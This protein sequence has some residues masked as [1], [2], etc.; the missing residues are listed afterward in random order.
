MPARA[1]AVSVIGLEEFGWEPPKARV[2]LG[3]ALDRH[4]WV[5]PKNVGWI[6]HW[7]WKSVQA[8]ACPGKFYAFRTTRHL[9]RH[10]GIYLHK[11]IALKRYG[12][13]P[14]EDHIVVDHLD[15]NSLNNLEE[16]LRWATPKQNHENR[17][18][19]WALQ[20]RMALRTHRPERIL[21]G[22]HKGRRTS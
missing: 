2:W 22:L 17:N 21:S 12:P 16:N 11:E 18:G 15:G 8:R 20:L 3:A 9:G 4:C 6:T 10:V 13:P 7:K 1:Q 5:D 14:S 19:F